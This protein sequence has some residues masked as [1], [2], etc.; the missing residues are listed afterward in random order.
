[1]REEREKLEASSASL[2]QLLL[3]VKIRQQDRSKDTET[4]TVN[5][6]GRTKQETSKNR[7]T[8]IK[9]PGNL[10]IPDASKEP[11]T[12]LRSCEVIF[13]TF[14]AHLLCARCHWSLMRPV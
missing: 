4:D 3:D 10:G 7:Q 12:A 1:M 14:P 8:Y 5:K 6:T 9:N 11:W 2:L 13:Q